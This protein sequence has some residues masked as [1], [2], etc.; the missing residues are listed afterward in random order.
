M[1]RSLMM[2][3]VLLLGLT[4]ATA[5]E[6]AT[7]N[8]RLKVNGSVVD[9]GETATSA[10]AGNNTLDVDVMV[11]DNFDPDADAD[12]GAASMNFDLTEN[13]GDPS[14]IPG[15]LEFEDELVFGSPTGSW[16]SSAPFSAVGYNHIKGIKNTQVLGEGPW[17]DI[18]QE[19]VNVNPSLQALADAPGA[20]V[21][22]T[23]VTGDFTWDGNPTSLTMTHVS[24]GLVWDLVPGSPAEANAEPPSGG[25]ASGTIHFGVPE[26]SS[27]ALVGICMLGMVVSARRQD[28]LG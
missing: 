9:W 23:I 21:W 10:V 8:F 12:L 18:L 20:G 24:P 19:F 3:A 16:D 28:R 6:A 17:Y 14:D 7:I 4:T 22:D 25:S 13:A 27:F 5:T 1:K 26:P 15:S 2:T 11:T